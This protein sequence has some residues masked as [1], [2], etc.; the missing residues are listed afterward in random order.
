V[1]CP[2]HESEEAELNI[3]FPRPD[4]GVCPGYLAEPRTSRHC[5]GIVIIHEM[6]GITPYIRG[7]AERCASEGYRALVPDLFRGRLP[8][9]IPGGLALMDQ[10][11]AAAAVA[12][13]VRGAARWLGRE[14]AA[15]A[16]MG[17]CMGGALVLLAA[18]RVPELCSAVCFYG[19]PPLETS[20]AASIRVPL[21]AHF[22]R[23]DDWCTPEKVA[24]LERVLRAGDVRYE[25][26][27]YDADHAFMNHDGNGYSEPASDLAWK[28][29][30]EF[31][32]RTLEAQ[33]PA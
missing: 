14:G 17:F 25:L 13:D 19:I 21:L 30:R 4:G 16:G 5:G 33:L 1:A 11:D 15:V 24:A 3:D 32:S 29:T 12:E 23:R 18:E 2:C 20:N 10:L 22:A 9:D 7:V 31:L 27:H 6:W 8:R 26:H 28:R